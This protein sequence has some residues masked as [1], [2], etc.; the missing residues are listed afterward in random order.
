MVRGFQSFSG[1]SGELDS[2]RLDKRTKAA[3]SSFAASNVLA[4]GAQSRLSTAYCF[5]RL[6]RSTCSSRLLLAFYA[7]L[8]MA[9]YS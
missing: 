5:H 8:R 4:R 6:H 3:K 7:A 9:P 1:D 2:L